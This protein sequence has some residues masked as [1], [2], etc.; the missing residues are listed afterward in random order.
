MK[1]IRLILFFSIITLI[2]AEPGLSQS[3]S[4]PKSVP[5]DP[6]II[7][8]RAIIDQAKENWVLDDKSIKDNYTYVEDRSITKYNFKSGVAD[9]AEQKTFVIKHDS[10]KAYVRLLGQEDNQYKPDK[11]PRFTFTI[12]ILE[13]FDYCFV[14]EKE[15]DSRKYAILNFSPKEG[16][17]KTSDPLEQAA[18]KL[19]GAI[20]VWSDNFTVKQ[21]DG[22]LFDAVS[23]GGVVKLLL[24]EIYIDTFNVAGHTIWHAQRIKFKIDTFSP[25]FRNYYELHTKTRD[26]FK[27][28]S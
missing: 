17:R 13:R 25:F 4:V 28:R 27:K 23:Y 14:E 21:F 26:N 10:G 3:K 15:L 7:R 22:K 6:N 8:G 20:Q 2:L 1:V 16:L 18:T 12:K 24:A 5:L 11:S 19:S 9:P